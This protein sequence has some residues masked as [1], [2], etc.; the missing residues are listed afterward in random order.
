MFS[1]RLKFK[2]F[3]KEEKKKPNQP[4]TKTNQT[5]E[6][7]FAYQ[8]EQHVD[9]V[10]SALPKRG[11]ICFTAQNSEHWALVQGQLCCVPYKKV[12]GTALS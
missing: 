11:S 6:G 7:T 10:P 9:P 2:E 4:T 12:P 8:K 3:L 5:N 1:Q